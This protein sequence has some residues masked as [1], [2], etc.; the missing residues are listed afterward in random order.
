MPAFTLPDFYLPYPARLN[1]HVERAREHS[2]GWARDLG[3]LDA[4]KPGGGVVWDEAPLR[5]MD[6]GLLVAHAHPDCDE[7]RVDNPIEYVQMRRRVGGAPWSANLVEYA[8]GAEVPDGVAHTR[9]MRVLSDS[10]SDAVH[11][12]NDLFSYQREVEREG[13]NANAVL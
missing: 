9:P 10:F 5:R 13:E 7:G 2:T 4:P 6:Y 1:P 3:M 12:R 11:L 8:A